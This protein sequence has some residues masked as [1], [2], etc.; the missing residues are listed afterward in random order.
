MEV[1]MCLPHPRLMGRPDEKRPG[2][3][4]TQAGHHGYSMPGATRERL[5][6]LVVIPKLRNLLELLKDKG[7]HC[8][9]IHRASYSPVHT[10]GLQ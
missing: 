5:F 6:C 3:S 1:L 10:R 7:L 4:F 8:F 9:S 2:K